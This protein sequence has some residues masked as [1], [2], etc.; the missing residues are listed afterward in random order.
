[1]ETA[2]TTPST[3]EPPKKK[4]LTPRGVVEYVVERKGT[5]SRISGLSSFAHSQRVWVRGY[6][7]RGLKVFEETVGYIDARST[8]PR[9]RARYVLER[10]E[11]LAEVLNAAEQA[12]RA[13][14]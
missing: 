2:S 12:K 10:A 1:M 9:S 7:E 8:G 4:L 5:T 13:V 14:H 6:D 11:R 3:H